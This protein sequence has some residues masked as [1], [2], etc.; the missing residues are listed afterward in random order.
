M[1]NSVAVWTESPPEKCDIHINYWIIKSKF[2]FRDHFI[3]F[4]IKLIDWQGGGVSLYLPL[5]YVNK[6]L[7]EVGKELRERELAN[8][9]FN[10]NCEITSSEN[11]RFEIKLPEEQLTVFVFDKENDV[12]SAQRYDGTLFTFEIPRETNN[13]Y[14][15]FRIKISYKEAITNLFKSGTWHTIRSSFSKKHTPKGSFYQSVRSS[16]EAVDFR[17]NDRRSL[18]YSLLDAHQNKFLKPRKLH[19]FLIYEDD[20]EFIYSTSKP[21]KDRL[22][23]NDVWGAYLKKVSGTKTKFCATHWACSPPSDEGWEVF[24][25]IRYGSANIVT[26]IWYLLLIISVALIVNIVSAYLYDKLNLKHFFDSLL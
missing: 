1:K 7:V 10:E 8:A 14:L 11:K 13:W 26:I 19:F 12:R 24:L 20:E 4:G 6:S 9:L 18:N 21:K 2:I 16:V 5:G 22:L 25:K 17:L 15:R 23:E 3:D